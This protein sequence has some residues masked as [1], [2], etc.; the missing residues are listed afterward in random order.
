MKCLAKLY[1]RKCHFDANLL[2]DVPP[3]VRR[4]Y[5][6]RGIKTLQELERSAHHLLSWK[7]IR[8]INDAVVLIYDMLKTSSRII[9]VGDFDADGATSTALVVLAL[10]SMGGNVDYIVPNRF[11]HGY[12][13]SPKIVECVRIRGADMILTVD[14][15]I[16]SHAGTVA[17]RQQGILVVIT[18][19]HLPDTTLPIA[20]AIVNPNLN[21]NLFPLRSLAGVGVAFYLMLALR[22]YLRQKDWFNNFRTEPK[23]A[24]LLDLVAIGTVTDIVPLNS[25]NRILVWQ[26]L[27]RIRSGKG[28][29]GINAM[30]NIANIN[31]SQLVTSDLGF[32]IGPRI[33]AAG[34]LNDISSSIALLITNDINKAYIL[35]HQLDMLNKTRKKLA[36]LM[37]HEAMIMCNLLKDKYG[38]LPHSLIFYDPKWHEGMVGILASWLKERFYRPVIAFAP[39]EKGILKGSGRSIV[40]LHLR[41]VLVQINK[42]FPGLI[43]KFGGHAMAV[44]LSI[45]QVKYEQFC[46]CFTEIINEYLQN[47]VLQHIIWSDG[48]LETWQ[49]SLH[50]AE[51]LRDA[52]PWGHEFPEPTFDGQFELLKQ[53]LI[54]NQHLKVL[55]KPIGGGPILEGINFNID[56]SVWPNKKLHYVKIAYKLNINNYGGNQSL[57]LIIDHI[58]S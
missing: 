33:N 28:R 52:G 12:G 47:K 10:R 56:P 42:L 15:G 16:A 21:S 57:Q 35:A 43:I 18:D 14:N 25:N 49:F 9:V 26:G 27:N 17:A 23:L 46:Q 32:V 31:K 13:L 55:L 6:Q 41:N 37:Q 29:I 40:D 8:G 54:C 39:G 11:E 53:Q 19:H 51:M 48:E 7:G 45:E 38:N 34:R 20:N 2:I 36:Q 24:E 58:W 44:G 1:R 3:L 4:I 22:A 50:T 5:L 30:L